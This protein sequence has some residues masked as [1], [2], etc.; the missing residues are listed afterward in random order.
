MIRGVII[1]W[2]MIQSHNL[3]VPRVPLPPMSTFCFV[4]F[5]V[6]HIHNIY[7]LQTLHVWDVFFDCCKSIRIIISCHT[8]NETT[9]CIYISSYHINPTKEFHLYTQMIQ[10]FPMS[11]WQCHFPL[12]IVI[13]GIYHY[14][15]III[16]SSITTTTESKCGRWR[17]I[18]ITFQSSEYILTNLPTRSMSNV[19]Y[20]VWICVG[21]AR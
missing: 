1:L 21:C 11:H 2:I 15:S 3:A 12:G 18:M 20:I 6:F 10:F 13:A 19:K 9:K 14:P 5:G 8:K 7:N 4:L 17:M 16:I